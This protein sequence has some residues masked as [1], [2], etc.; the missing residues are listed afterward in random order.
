MIV[1]AINIDKV[2]RLFMFWLGRCV[3]ERQN[4]PQTAGE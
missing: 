2:A 4:I 3:E 1:I